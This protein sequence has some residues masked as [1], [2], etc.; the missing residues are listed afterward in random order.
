MCPKLNHVRDDRME[1]VIGTIRKFRIA[2][3]L[4]KLQWLEILQ[5]SKML[6]MNSKGLKEQHIIKVK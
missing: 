1:K 4:Q 2:Q 5:R 6:K 3:W